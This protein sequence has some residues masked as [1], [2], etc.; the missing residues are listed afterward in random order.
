VFVLSL[1]VDVGTAATPAGA[2]ALDRLRAWPGEHRVAVGLSGGVDSSLTAALLVQAGWQV[3]GL[4]LWLMSGKGACCAEG[5]VDAAGIC[6]QLGVPHHVVDFREHFRE[7]I[8]DFVVQGYQAGVTP[9]PCSRCNR[10]VKFGPMLRWAREERGIGRIATGHYARISPA[11]QT[12][13]GRHQLLRG[14]D[15]HKDQSYFLYDL[16]QESLGRLVFPLGELTKADTRAEAAQHGLRTATKPESQDL[17]LADHH[18]SMRAFLDTYLP[19]RQ[20]EIVLVDGTVV[21][22]HAGIQH[23]TIGQRKG[24]GVAWREPLHVVRLDAAMNRVV[25]APRREAARA[26]AVVG[27]VNW[28]S[29]APPQVEIAVEVQVRYRSGAVAARLLPLPPTEADGEAGRPHRC[30][31]VF[32]E[33]QFSITPGQAAVFYDGDVLLGGGL[34]QR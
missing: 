21:G 18:G 15:R 13:N 14:R 25:V 20:G 33:E 31:L 2:A 22:Q 28:V 3:E 26:D 8:V 11:E 5:L 12:D 34:I 24:L 23:F 30:R 10:E 6:E 16:P 29:I 17:C 1:A 9:L 4:T 32:A 27:A 19:P 7:Q